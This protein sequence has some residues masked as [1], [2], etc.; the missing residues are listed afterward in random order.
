MVQKSE[1]ISVLN[2]NVVA[3]VLQLI[4]TFFS[5]P[6]KTGICSPST[7][8]QACTYAQAHTHIL[9]VTISQG[10]LCQ[11]LVRGRRNLF[12]WNTPPSTSPLFFCTITQMW[13]RSALERNKKRGSPKHLKR[14]AKVSLEHIC[15]L[16]STTA[17]GLAS[18]WQS[19]LQT[20]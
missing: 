20:P 5:F 18:W 9:F 3:C 12:W 10:Q 8:I 15:A 11:H 2:K 13:K 4:L 7:G 19:F 14:L 17:E 1:V 16:R 6:L